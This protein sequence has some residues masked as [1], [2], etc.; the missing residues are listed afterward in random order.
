[1]EVILLTD[2]DGILRERSDPS[3]RISRLTVDEAEALV[4][5]RTVSAGMLPKIAA[6]ASPNRMA[7]KES[8]TSI[9][10]IT[11]PSARW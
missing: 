4:K 3:S 7:G 5:D 6:I 8:S 11:T 2:V 1:M 9:N 10:R